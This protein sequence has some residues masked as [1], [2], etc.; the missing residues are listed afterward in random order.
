MGLFDNDFY[1][2]HHEIKNKAAVATLNDDTDYVRAIDFSVREGN[3]Y[4]IADNGFARLYDINKISLVN[5]FSHPQVISC[6]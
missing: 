4:T 1:S 6:S 5:S 2:V 3:L